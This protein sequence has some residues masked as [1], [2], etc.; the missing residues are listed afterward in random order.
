MLYSMWSYDFLMIRIIYI[1]SAYISD[2][3]KCVHTVIYIYTVYSGL[4][5]L[6]FKKSVLLP[7]VWHLEIYFILIFNSSTCNTYQYL[8]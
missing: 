7:S 4:F 8:I 6:F 1:I 5:I 3:T 2:P